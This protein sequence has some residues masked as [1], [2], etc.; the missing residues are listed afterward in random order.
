MN[1][2]IGEIS[3]NRYGTRIKIIN[4]EGWNKVTI[5]FEDG[6]IKENIRYSHFKEGSCISPYDKTVF[7]VGYLRRRT[8]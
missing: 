6:Y 3:Y 5:Q 4:Y 8:I 2:R 7:G 1:E